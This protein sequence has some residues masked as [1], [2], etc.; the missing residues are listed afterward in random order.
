MQVETYILLHRM[1]GVANTQSE[2]E[3]VLR[4]FQSIIEAK[5]YSTD[6]DGV[7]DAAWAMS[8][9]AGLYLRLNESFLAYRNYAEAIRLFDKNKMSGNSAALRLIL[10]D[11]LVRQGHRTEAEAHLRDSVRYLVRDWGE[12]HRFVANAREEL[13]HFQ[14]TGEVRQA[15]HHR[16]CQVCFDNYKVGFEE[17]HGQTKGRDDVWPA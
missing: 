12:T 8:C 14:L 1:L 2:I 6:R 15:I 10:A 3:I 11:M 5:K 7:F 16:W 17:E 4:R 9:A 13:R